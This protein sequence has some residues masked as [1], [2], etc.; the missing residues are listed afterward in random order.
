MSNRVWFETGRR[1][2][3]FRT[4]SALYGLPNPVWSVSGAQPRARFVS[5]ASPSLLCTGCRTAS[6]LYRGSRPV[7]IG[8]LSACPVSNVTRCCCCCCEGVKVCRN[9]EHRRSS[10]PFPSS[11]QWRFSLNVLLFSPSRGTSSPQL[12]VVHGYKTGP[13]T[14]SF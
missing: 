1:K 9:G 2:S 10:L 4:T 14:I 11:R 7:C 5:G 6:D 12:H 8:G 13:G 3:V